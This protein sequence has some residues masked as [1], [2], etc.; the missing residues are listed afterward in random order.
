VHEG[1][2]VVQVELGLQ[3]LRERRPLPHARRDPQLVLRVAVGKPRQ[4][5]DHVVRATHRPGHLVAV[6]LG[7]LL[8]EGDL[9]VVVGMAGRPVPVHRRGDMVGEERTERRA[10]GRQ[11]LFEGIEGKD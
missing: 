2:Q 5:A 3:R 6:L 8:V 4:S 9:G 7:P 1:R 10:G 11:L